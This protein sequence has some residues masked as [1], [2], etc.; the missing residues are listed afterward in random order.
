MAVQFNAT[1]IGDKELL[2]KLA[3]LEGRLRGDVS[4]KALNVGAT[5]VLQAMRKTVPVGDTGN[6]RHSLGKKVKQY[7]SGVSIAVVGPRIPQ[8]AH[9]HLLESGT[10]E[11]RHKKTGRRT[12]RVVG[13][14]WMER[15]FD[16]S[17]PIASE[18]MIA[19]VKAR[20]DNLGI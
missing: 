15:A 4:R 16:E 8:G 14:R 7:R 5:P 13:I 2:R 12:G 9:A 11:R 19:Y 1:L 10:K 17:S 6:L 18:R 20:L 3:N